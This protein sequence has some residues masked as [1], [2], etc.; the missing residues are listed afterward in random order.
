MNNFYKFLSISAIV[1]FGLSS[2]NNQQ[3]AVDEKDNVILEDVYG[4]ADRVLDG[5]SDNFI[6]KLADDDS[7]DD[8]FELS[9]ENGMILISG[10]N[11]ISL[12]SGLNYYL[13]KYCNSQYTIIDKQMNLPEKL[14]LPELVERVSTDFEY[15]YFFNVCTFGYTMA[16]WEWEEWERQI[17]WMAMNGINMP[18]AITGQEAV[19]YEVYK[20]LGFSDKQIAEF[21]VGPAYLPWGW[22]GNVDGLGGP[23]PR[24]WMEK[25]KELQNKILKRERSFGMTPVLQAFSGHVPESLKDVYPEAS[26]RKTGDWSAGFGGTYFLDPSDSLF[27]RIG[28]LFIEKQTEMYGTD[29]YYSADCFNEINPDTDDPDFLASMSKT[30]YNTISAADSQA[31]WVMQ[32]WFLYYSV[33]DFWKEP[34]SKALLGGVADDKMIILDLYGEFH[35]TWKKQSS[36]YGKPWIWNV[37]HN[38]GGRTSMSGKLYDIDNGLDEA[39]NS[40]DKGNLSGIGMAMEYFGNNPVIQE[41]V[42]DK[43]WS[44]GDPD[45]ENWLNSYVENRY[46]TK[47][48]FADKAWDGMLKTVYNTHKQTGTFLCERPGFY[49]SELSYRTSPIPD[50]DQQVLTQA[51]GDLLKCADN[52]RDLDTYQFDLVNLTRQFISPLAYNWILELEDAY[53]NNDMGTFIRVK[54]QFT[55]LLL[56]FDLLLASRKEYLLGSWLEDAKRWGDTD[57]EKALYEWN[58]RNIITLWGEECT[59][60]Q[61]DDLNTYAYK[62]WSGLF[63]DYHLVRWNRFFNEVEEAMKSNKEWDRSVFLESSCQWE[64]NWSLERNTFQS[65]PEGD[66]VKLS[67]YI[68]DKYLPY[69]TF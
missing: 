42:M 22:M 9:S 46:G 10:K 13:K 65:S 17:D 40:P 34:Q 44:T 12:A 63:T 30:V 51:L 2:C 21:L 61:Y 60:G 26:L 58:A 4:L 24:S 53:L 50:Y 6:F 18:L 56:D 66:P 68:W 37:L 47:N 19:W 28:K 38:F 3:S 31:V 8:F 39:I 32:A 41:Y 43:V 52:F 48:E 49:N 5:R 67:K 55:S 11:G 62:Q 54:S 7:G 15:R 69:M 35:P 1:V 36:F 27:N 14:P 64:K 25:H 23:L 29:H 33:G 45:V 59:E 20:E 16:W 57:E